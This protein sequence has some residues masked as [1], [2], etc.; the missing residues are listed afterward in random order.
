MAS[1]TGW[2]WSVNPWFVGGLGYFGFTLYDA[3]YNSCYR[4][5]QGKNTLKNG[6]AVIF[7]GPTTVGAEDKWEY[8]EK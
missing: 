3:D 8:Q 1:S 7:D 2:I 4:E 6:D 5:F